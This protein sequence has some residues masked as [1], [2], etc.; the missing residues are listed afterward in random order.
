MEEFACPV[1]QR[2]FPMAGGEGVIAHLIRDHWEE[3]L[4]R[5]IAY[6]HFSRLNMAQ[7]QPARG[8]DPVCIVSVWVQGSS[9]NRSLYLS[10]SVPLTPERLKLLGRLVGHD[11]WRRQTTPEQATW[12]QIEAEVLGCP[13]D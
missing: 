9:G 12:E 1:C 11:Q 7:Q 3:P 8:G 13:E 6:S 5:A 4:A 10:E 2:L